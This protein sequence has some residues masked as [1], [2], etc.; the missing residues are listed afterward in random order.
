VEHGASQGMA[1]GN[2]ARPGEEDHGGHSSRRVT[3]L[4]VCPRKYPPLVI[5]RG[6]FGPDC[7]RRADRVDLGAFA[8]PAWAGALGLTVSFALR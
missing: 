7:W 4:F 6:P 2:C 1:V 8:R 5:W 3:R